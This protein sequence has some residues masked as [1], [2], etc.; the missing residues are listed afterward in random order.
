M[1]E[2][3]RRELLAVSSK[4]R[5]FCTLREGLK[6]CDTALAVIPDAIAG[7]YLFKTIGCSTCHVQTLS[8][9]H[10]GPVIG[11]STYTVPNALGDKI[12][13]PY[14]DFLLH[15]VGTGD[16]IVQAGPQDTANKLRTVPLW[17]MHVKSRFTHDN[18]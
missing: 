3:P 4:M 14:G 6:L 17:S 1:W 12:I 9:D 8:T 13:H 5:K 15:D 2:R 16:G 7:E 18:A 11:G 10:P